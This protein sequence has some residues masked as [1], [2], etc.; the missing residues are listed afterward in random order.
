MQT[1][2]TYHLPKWTG[3]LVWYNV[4]G[5]TNPKVPAQ[6]QKCVEISVEISSA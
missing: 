6:S 1:E 2:E 3:L 5:K 4:D